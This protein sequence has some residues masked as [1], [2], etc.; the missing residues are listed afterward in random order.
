MYRKYTTSLVS[1]G[2]SQRCSHRCYQLI[3]LSFY[4][5]CC[6]SST[7]KGGGKNST[8]GKNSKIFRLRRGA[9]IRYFTLFGVYSNHKRVFFRLST[10]GGENFS[11]FWVC[12]CVFT[13]KNNVFLKDFTAKILKK[14]SASGGIFE[15]LPPPCTRSSTHKGG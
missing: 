4:P 7:H 11:T 10:A 12:F 13:T 1:C 5:P 8:G 9:E 3:S 14:F 2:G 6:K 15:F